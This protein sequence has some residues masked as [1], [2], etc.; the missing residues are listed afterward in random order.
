[1]LAL[2]M[3]ASRRVLVVENE[4]G[5]GPE[6]FGP[7]L[8]ASGIW[9]ELCRPYKGDELPGRPD[10][11]AVMVLGG[12]MGALDDHEAPW[13]ARTRTMLADAV[14]CGLP[15]LGI[16][17]GAQLLAAACGG[18]VEPSRAGGELGLGRIDL[19]DEARRDRLFAAVSS[20][21]QAVQAHD[22]DITRLPTGAVL[23]A[24]SPICEVEA[25]RMGTS[26]WGVQFHP[27]ANS[28]VL[29][30]WADAERHAPPER[31]RRLA[32]AV[33]EVRGADGLLAGYWRKLAE[34]FAA[35]VK[36]G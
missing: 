25:Y 4:P 8:T 20:P 24:S 13:L 29:K 31:R 34:A 21:A 6:M 22:D 36:A 35:V 28:S 16:C 23:L 18:V 27:E 32:E 10:H 1:M 17:L 14:G 33:A 5:A 3:R 2:D 26:A 19:N 30:A 9:L 15:V 11:D 7:W 12:S